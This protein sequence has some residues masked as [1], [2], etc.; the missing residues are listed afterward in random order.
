[1]G[2]DEVRIYV[3]LKPGRSLTPEELVAYCE[4]RMAYFMIPRYVEFMD[5][6]PKTTTE[7][8]LKAALKESGLNPNTWDR[9]KA[10]Y[11]VRR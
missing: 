11:K 1:M 2:E 5:A 3:V 7:K 4:P 9:E 8:V 6:L 10:G